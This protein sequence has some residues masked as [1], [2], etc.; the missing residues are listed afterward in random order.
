[1]KRII[2]MTIILGSLFFSF[3]S[4]AGEVDINKHWGI[5][6]QGNFPLVGGV[7]ARYYGLSPVYLQIVGR[8]ILN[9]YNR[10]NM[11]GAG[12]SYAV[13]EHVSSVITRLYFS[14]EGGERYEKD[15]WDEYTEYGPYGPVGPQRRHISVKKTYGVGVAFGTEITI[16][17]FGTQVGWNAEV[18]QGLGRIKEDRRSE[19]TGSIILGTGI[20]VYF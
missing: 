8:F 18:G 15:V 19:D 16:P 1:M 5:G 20:H 9:D 14:L 12:I 17:F 13:L 6:L 3:S 11:L 4:H 10:D 2:C 7:S